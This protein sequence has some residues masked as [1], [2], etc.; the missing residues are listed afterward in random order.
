MS[1]NM[2]L[3]CR[4]VVPKTP[5]GTSA[6]AWGLRALASARSD[7]A[8]D[9]ARL[10]AHLGRRRTLL[11]SGVSALSADIPRE[12]DGRISRGEAGDRMVADS[13]LVVCLRVWVERPQSP[14]GVILAFAR[15]EVF[16]LGCRGRLLPFFWALCV[17]W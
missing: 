14:V 15:V 11:F 7:G 12:L 17:F 3:R 4:A 6:E 9:A 10:D 13:T 2:F 5:E 8:H 16:C 1:E